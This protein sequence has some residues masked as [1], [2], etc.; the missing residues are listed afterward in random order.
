MILAYYAATGF[1]RFDTWSELVEECLLAERRP[2]RVWAENERGDLIQADDELADQVEEAQ[3][4]AAD[5][6]RDRRIDATWSV[7]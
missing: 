7:G 3:A 5:I 1:G 6:A 4:E 2:S